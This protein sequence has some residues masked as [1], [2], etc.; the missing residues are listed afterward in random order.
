MEIG[1]FIDLDIR[2]SGEYYKGKKNIARLNSARAGIYHAC[3]LYQCSSIYIPY[4]LC[5]IV[6]IFLIERGIEIK[7]YFINDKF[8]PISLDQENDHAFLLVNYFGILSLNKMKMLANQ[9]K[10]VIID[11]SASFYCDP[12]AE[13]YNIYSPRKFFGVP[14]GCYVIGNEAD[15][16]TDQYEQD[17]SSLTATFLLKRIEFGLQ[18]TYEERM[19]NEERINHSGIL[20]MSEL[21]KSLLNNIDYLNIK[22]KRKNNF[23]FANKLFRSM[24]KID[25]TAYIDR[26]SVP[27]VYPLVIENSYLDNKLRN[28][29]I[30]TGR[31]WNHVLSEVSDSSFEAWL[32]KYMIPTPIDQRYNKK[33]IKYIQ[34]VLIND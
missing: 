31:W 17:F 1:S 22:L 29:Q 2:D 24:N 14:D 27:M 21:T 6:K 30:F 23:S 18:P 32:S 26:N 7:P 5:P 13:C 9:F 12:I 25:P 33:E 16:F 10:N 11:N 20:K 34:H 4:Y 15:K 3:R 19:K 8:E 28:N